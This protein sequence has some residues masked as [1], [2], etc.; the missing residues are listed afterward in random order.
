MVEDENPTKLTTKLT[1]KGGIA[2]FAIL[3]PNVADQARL[4]AVACI[5]LVGQCVFVSSDTESGVSME[6][7]T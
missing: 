4:F 2:H 3:Y 6:L 7:P 1:T 5:R